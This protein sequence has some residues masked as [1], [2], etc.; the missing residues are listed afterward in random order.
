MT[1]HSLAP[2]PPRILTEDDPV[3]LEAE[4]RRR[5]G[6]IDRGE[7]VMIPEEEMWRQVFGDEPTSRRPRRPR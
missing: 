5:L 7:V 4:L 6:E 3:A 2:R 1:T